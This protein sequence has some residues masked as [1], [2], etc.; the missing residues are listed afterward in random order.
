[1]SWN[2]ARALIEL[3]YRHIYWFPGGAAGWAAEGKP[4][5]NASVYDPERAGLVQ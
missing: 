5:V 2:A 3:G 1:M 4:L